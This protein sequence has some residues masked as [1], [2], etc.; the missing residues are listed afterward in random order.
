[1]ADDRLW[2]TLRPDQKQRL[3][4]FA[5][6]Q[7]QSQAAI[8]RGLIE[9]LPAVSDAVPPPAENATKQTNIRL[10]D[11]ECRQLD[12][13]AQSAGYAGR[14]TWVQALVRA[15]LS[16]QPMLTLEELKAVADASRQLAHVG[17]NLN[18]MAR[19]LN[20]DAHDADKPTVAF[21]RDLSS[22][23]DSLRHEI[24]ALADAS[25]RQWSV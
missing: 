14:A 2:L 9:Y 16:K 4:A 24:R 8:I 3:A 7:Q 23:I 10:T 12:S 21:L 18:Q 5:T 20:I 11:D 15:N 17:R 25:D 19:A 13:L 22:Q 6:Q 1:M